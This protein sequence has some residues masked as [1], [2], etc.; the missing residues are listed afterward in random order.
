MIRGTT[1]TLR[2][3]MPY[4]AEQIKSGYI[5]FTAQGNVLLDIPVNDTNVKITDG[6]ISLTLTQQQ[7]LMF[8]SCLLNLVQL[9]LVLNDNSVVAS[10]IVKISVENILKDGEI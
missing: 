7:T 3:T 4:T 6:F 10:N 1:P 9:R 2:F 8:K 5:T